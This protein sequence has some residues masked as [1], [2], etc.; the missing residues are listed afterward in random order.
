MA[1]SANITSN[2][3]DASS[4]SS[5]VTNAVSITSNVTQSTAVTANVITGAKGDTGAT[6][7]AGADGATGATGAAG[8]NTVSTSTTTNITGVLK[9]NGSTVSGAVANTDYQSPISLTTTGTGAA[10]FVSNTLNIP[11]PSAGT[12]S[13]TSVSV[14]T[15]N[16]V[17]GSV[18]TA[19]TTPAISLTLGAITPSSV[20]SVVLS[21]SSTPTLA[22][23]GTTSVSGTHSGTSSG[24]NTGDQT[25]ISGN[26][27]TAT[28]LQ[29]ARTIGTLTG[30]VTS[31]GSTFNGSANNTNA[32]V[33]GKINGVALSGLATGIL[34]NT[35]TTGIPSIA[36]AADFPTLNQ[37]TTGTAATV[38]TNAN[39]TGVITS[40]GNATSIASQT[41]TGTKFV[42]DTSPTIVTPTI[43]SFTNATHNHTNAVGGGQLTATTALST[44][45]T[46]SGTTFLRGDNVWATP[47]GSGDMVLASVQ[48]N[49]GAKTFNSGTL[50]AAGA[51]SGTTTLNATAIAGTTTLTLPAATDTLVGKATTD[52]LTNKTLTAPVIFSP[53]T[54]QVG[55]TEHSLI[56]W[57]YD[58]MAVQSG[59]KWTTNGTIYL[60]KLHIPIA[61]SVT[62]IIFYF[63]AAGAT[64][65]AGQNFAGIYQSGTLLGSTADQQT[66]WQSSGLKTMAISGGPIAVAAGDLYIAFFGNGTTLPTMGR[67]GSQSSVI[68]NVG[69]LATASRFGSADTGRTTTLP[70][71]LG[72]VAGI[73]DTYW[74][75]IS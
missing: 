44:T 62:N 36:V 65:T 56:A 30:D 1:D 34:K 69:L 75:A 22:V 15:A 38:T 50:I 10:T 35:T 16:G 68:A 54:Q 60:T 40:I 55:P 4:I 3:T 7:A 71:T 19:T 59:T 57:S 67:S 63:T 41:G 52:T 51:T 43:A 61:Q 14:T 6:G 5:N 8:P 53:S 25:T 72:T 46:P 39:L 42:V 48:T 13:V 28:T 37:N 31:A 24:T 70:A 33:V 45:G 49:T 17:S 64:L 73:S 21:G 18:A 9:G 58:P 2:V 74:A 26:A 12:G 32:T 66:N 27:G 20:N 23:T 47:A 29:T 11:T